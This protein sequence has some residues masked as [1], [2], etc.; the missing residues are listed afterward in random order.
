MKA[1]NGNDVIYTDKKRNLIE[2]RKKS[3]LKKVHAVIIHFRHQNPDKTG[4]KLECWQLTGV[5]LS[6]PWKQFGR[7]FFSPK[8]SSY[9]S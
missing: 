4:N 5:L 7:V 8:I 6:L 3:D 1:I 9:G 2:I